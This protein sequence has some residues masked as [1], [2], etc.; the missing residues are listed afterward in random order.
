MSNNHC[1]F[2]SIVK[3]KAAEIFHEDEKVLVIEPLCPIVNGH[4]L[5]FPKKHFENILDIDTD[6]LLHLTSTTQNVAR[7][8]V[9]DINAGGVNVLHAAGKVAQQSVQHFHYHIVPRFS[10]DGLDLWL[11]NNL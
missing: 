1:V 8:L 11:K 9:L 4:L 10:G 2:C 3:T 5:V 6:L 7:K